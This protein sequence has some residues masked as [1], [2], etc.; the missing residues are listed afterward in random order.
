MYVSC[1]ITVKGLVIPP[2]QI[3]VHILS[4][5]FLTAP[6]T[7]HL[8]LLLNHQ[9]QIPLCQYNITIESMEKWSGSKW[10]RPLSNISIFFQEDFTPSP[11]PQP[12]RQSYHQ[13]Q[14]TPRFSHGSDESPGC[15]HQN[16]ESAPKVRSSPSGCQWLSHGLQT[17]RFRRR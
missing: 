16:N 5:L 17:F 10:P 9:E 13:V 2:A 3:S 8:F 7:I 1:S 14:L 4:T 12:L 11:I 6:V 15:S